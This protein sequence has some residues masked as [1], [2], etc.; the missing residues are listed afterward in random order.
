[1]EMTKVKSSNIASIGYDPVARRMRIAF[2][3]ATYDYNGVT[4]GEYMAL[5]SAPSI[6]KYFAAHIRPK[7]KGVRV[8]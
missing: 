4:E 5:L 6:G 1:M 7:Y 3:G 8:S 2:M